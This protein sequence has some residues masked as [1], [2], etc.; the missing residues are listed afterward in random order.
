VDKRTA[1][2]ITVVLLLLLACGSRSFAVWADNSQT[3]GADALVQK[4]LTIAE[5]DRELERLKREDAGLTA[6]I[7]ESEAKLAAQDKLAADKRRHA[8]Q[9]LRAYYMGERDSLWVL[10][11]SLHSFRDILKTFEYL[12]MILAGDHRKLADYTAAMNE[13]KRLQNELVD[14]QARLRQTEA[15]YLAQRDRLQKLQDELDRQL[16]GNAEAQTVMKRIESVTAEW[17]QRGIPLFR[18]YFDALAEAMK[19][20]PELATA[21]P[22][23]K[24]RLTLDG[25]NATFS[26]T[27]AD[28][29]DFLRSR[30]PLFRDLAFRFVKDGVTAE[31][32]SDGMTLSLQG[33]YELDPAQKTIGFHVLKLTFNGYELPDTTVRDLERQVDLSFN[34]K[35]LVSFLEPTEVR[36]EEGKLTVRMKLNL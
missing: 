10:L 20:L 26:I 22:D 4:G 35:T 5:I 12:S 25:L 16:A 36:Q 19:G 29:N 18:K 33:A 3:G 11:F 2:S 6:R 15:D 8:G 1:V 7:A 30:N 24:T 31:G 17:Q 13:L 9:V 14:A 27:D 23:G 28:L 34:P 32:K 21:S